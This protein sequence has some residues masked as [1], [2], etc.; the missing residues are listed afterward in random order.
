[1]KKL[2][3][4]IC[5]LLVIFLGMFFNKKSVSKSNVTVSEVEEI[6]EFISKIYLWK[7]ISEEALPKFNNINEAPDLWLWEVVK[8]NLEQYE[9]TYDEIQQ[10]AKDIFGENFSK[11]FPKEGTEYIQF[12]ENSQKYLITGVGLDTLEDMFFVKNINKISNEKYEVQIIEYL[13]DYSDEIIAYEEYEEN[14]ENQENIIEEE[15]QY[16]IY[17]RNLDL[18]EVTKIKNTDSESIAIEKIKENIDKFSIKTINI[19]KINDNMYVESVNK[20]E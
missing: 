19:I 8:K 18:D 17:I 15:I 2:L 9:L 7:E 10:K 14:S 11:E 12:D 1:M 3:V 13:Q 6:Q 5:I 20:Y 16:D 4:A